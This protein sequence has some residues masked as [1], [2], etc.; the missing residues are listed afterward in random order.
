MPWGHVSLAHATTPLCWSGSPISLT[1]LERL[2]ASL[3]R[4]CAHGFAR[5]N[6][7]TWPSDSLARAVMPGTPPTARAQA[8]ASR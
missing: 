5:T 7:S 4:K 8:S 3:A 6:A 2:A 1:V